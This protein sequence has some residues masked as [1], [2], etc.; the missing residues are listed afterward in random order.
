MIGVDLVDTDRIKA[1]LSKNGSSFLAK[2][3]S[4]KEQKRLQLNAKNL[5]VTNQT[6]N[7]V[8]GIWALKE[9]TAKALGCGIGKKLGFKDIS[10][11]KTKQGA[12]FVC[13]S[14]PA[15][16]IFKRKKLSASISHE[17]N[18]LV[19]VVIFV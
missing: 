9:A 17:K 3:L 18:M 7:T 5:C 8:A 13:L 6:V 10:V 1:V 2:I 19:G 11:C 15:Q 12:P 4:K 16:K 14:K